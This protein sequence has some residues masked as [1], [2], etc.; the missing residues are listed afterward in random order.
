VGETAVFEE[1]AAAPLR[2]IVDVV[3]FTD[4]A[5]D[6]G[7]PAAG[8]SAADVVLVTI[9]LRAGTFLAGGAVEVVGDRAR[10]WFSEVEAT[11]SDLP[12][13]APVSFGVTG[14][15]TVGDSTSG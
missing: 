14:V 11:E 5:K 8:L 13:V 10:L 7:R 2:R 4:A 6:L 12:N 3:D 1:E 9:I 15:D